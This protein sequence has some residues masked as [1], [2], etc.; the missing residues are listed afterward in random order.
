MQ[1]SQPGRALGKDSEWVVLAHR[2]GF[3]VSQVLVDGLDWEIPDRYQDQ[4][5]DTERQGK[6]RE[7]YDAKAESWA[8]RVGIAVEIAEAGVDALRRELATQRQS[9]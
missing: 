8:L 6:I 5:A 3:R 7:E 2:G 1:N 9:E 4:A